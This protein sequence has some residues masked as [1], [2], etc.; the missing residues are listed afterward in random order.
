MGFSF[1]L[2]IKSMHRTVKASLPGMLRKGAGSN[3]NLSSGFSSI[4]GLPNRYVYG[5]TKGTVIGLTKAV[6][7]DFITNGIGCDDICPGTIASPYFEERVTAVSK[8]SAALVQ[9]RAH[10]FNRMTAHGT[11]GNIRGVRGVGGFSR[12]G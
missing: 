6:A 5:A 9:R 7:A 1:D 3:T 10:Q 2:K 12:V 11:P 8:Q 4:N